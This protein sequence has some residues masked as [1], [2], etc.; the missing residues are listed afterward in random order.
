MHKLR[1]VLTWVDMPQLEEGGWRLSEPFE[2]MIIGVRDRNQLIANLNAEVRKAREEQEQEAGARGGR[3]RGRE[4]EREG[5]GKGGRRRRK[6]GREET[7]GGGGRRKARGR[8]NNQGHGG[9]SSRVREGL[10]ERGEREGVKGGGI[11]GFGGDT[12]RRRM[13]EAMGEEG[14]DGIRCSLLW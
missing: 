10:E 12:R 2:M 5:K 13:E 11:E 14:A 3:R 9:G 8:S 7:G 6:E 4:K 1:D